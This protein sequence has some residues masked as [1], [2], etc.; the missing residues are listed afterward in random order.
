MFRRFWRTG[1]HEV[2]RSLS[3][4]AFVRA[5]QKL[6]PSLAEQDVVRAGAGVRAQAVGPDGKLVD[7]FHILETEKQ[8]H[9]LNAPSPAA[10]A[11]LSIGNHIAEL[12]TTRFEL[13]TKS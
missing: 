8:I 2:H 13:S 4:R 12:A 1:I 10:T 5:L 11:S 6:I 9:V 7:D 3:K